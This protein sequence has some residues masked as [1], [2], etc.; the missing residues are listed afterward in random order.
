MLRPNNARHTQL[1][2]KIVWC[3]L[4]VNIQ[5]EIQPGVFLVMRQL[6]RADSFS[7]IRSKVIFSGVWTYFLRRVDGYM[8]C[9]RTELHGCCL[10]LRGLKRFQTGNAFRSF[11]Q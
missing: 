10:T 6:A 7:R 9:S 8:C 4:L 3:L 2:Q 1:F 11:V 5:N